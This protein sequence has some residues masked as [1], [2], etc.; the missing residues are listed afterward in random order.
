MINNRQIMEKLET[1]LSEFAQGK[2]TK[3]EILEEIEGYLN[4]LRGNLIQ[5]GALFIL[6]FLFGIT[7]P[8]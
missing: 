2:I 7:V 6:G 8:F 1:R 4:S 5:Y 3:E